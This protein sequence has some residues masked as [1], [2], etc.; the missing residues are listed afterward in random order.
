MKVAK[1][2]AIASTND[3]EAVVAQFSRDADRLLGGKPTSSLII[4]M[5][6]TARSRRF[7]GRWT[8]RPPIICL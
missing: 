1:A 5:P 4:A 8:V 6:G 7:C 2:P 3:H